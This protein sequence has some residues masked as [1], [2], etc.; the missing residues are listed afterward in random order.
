MST[1]QRRPVPARNGARKRRSIGGRG[2]IRET[3]RGSLKWAFV[4]AFGLWLVGKGI[5]HAPD[6][7]PEVTPAVPS[8][9]VTQGVA[10]CCPAR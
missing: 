7:P 1:P 3:K 8:T 5:L 4:V 2:F 10:P 6:V 9:S